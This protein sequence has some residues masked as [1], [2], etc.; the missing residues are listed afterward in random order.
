MGAMIWSP[1]MDKGRQMSFI[2][3]QTYGNKDWLSSKINICGKGKKFWL[4]GEKI[5]EAGHD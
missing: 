1:K 5:K 2:I 3:K 4:V